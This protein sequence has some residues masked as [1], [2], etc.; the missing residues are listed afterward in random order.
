MAP[1]GTRCVALASFLYQTSPRRSLAGFETAACRPGPFRW[2]LM[3]GWHET[4]SALPS[5]VGAVRHWRAG[6]R[7]LAAPRRR[8]GI[9]HP[10]PVHVCL[11]LRF[12][13]PRL[14]TSAPLQGFEP[15]PCQRQALTCVSRCRK[16]W[17]D[18]NMSPGRA[19]ESAR[20]TL[21]RVAVSPM[22]HDTTLA[23]PQHR[24]QAAPSRGGR[25]DVPTCQPRQTLTSSSTRPRRFC[26]LSGQGPTKAAGSSHLVRD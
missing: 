18:V 24:W 23:A 25:G 20:I 8:H 22:W 1:S 12:R 21:R 6:I 15:E 19:T 10:A 17:P 11:C 3:S 14:L 5:T 7:R 26:R 4:P 16:Q 9:I 2:L 13:P